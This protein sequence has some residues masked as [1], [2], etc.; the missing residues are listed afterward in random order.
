MGKK[1]KKDQAIPTAMTK[2]M[3]NLGTSFRERREFL[4]I[5]YERAAQ[6][7][8]LSSATIRRIETGD[9]GVS[10]RVLVAYLNILGAGSLFLD[11]LTKA[12]MEL[13]ENADKTA[14]IRAIEELRIKMLREKL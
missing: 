4:G 10:I 9:C 2:A 13:S 6:I 1:T 7:T 3:A 5:S 14:F 12:F 11:S 8:G